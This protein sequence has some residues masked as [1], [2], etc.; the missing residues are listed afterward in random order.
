MTLAL[1]RKGSIMT[2][3]A[4]P[5]HQHIPHEEGPTTVCVHTK[6]WES[7]CTY[8]RERGYSLILYKPYWYV[9]PQGVGFWRRNGLKTGIDFAHFSLELVMDF[10]EI[11]GVY[12]C[13]GRFNSK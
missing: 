13:I 7:H 3:G 5:L 12:E 1:S 6:I 4:S 8:P 2:F 9:Q 11:T 10:E